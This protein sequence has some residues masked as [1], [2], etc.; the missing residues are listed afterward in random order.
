M[1]ENRIVYV[2]T[3][4][5]ADIASDWTIVVGVADEEEE[6]IELGINTRNSDYDDK[7]SVVV[8]KY[9]NKV[10]EE[11]IIIRNGKTTRYYDTEIKIDNI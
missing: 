6:A 9:V 5:Y 11:T 10:I 3:I 4:N 2:I 8:Y 7:Y 1:S